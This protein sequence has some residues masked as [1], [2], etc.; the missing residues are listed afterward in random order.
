M[1]SLSGWG[2]AAVTVQR[3]DGRT[4]RHFCLNRGEAE[5]LAL[6]LWRELESECASVRIEDPAT[7]RDKSN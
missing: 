7:S 3:E 2:F 1:G 4:E 5:R 6:R